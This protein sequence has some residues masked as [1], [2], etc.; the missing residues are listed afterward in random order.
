LRHAA[1]TR[2]LLAIASERPT[3][4][5]GGPKVPTG[6]INDSGIESSLL[7]DFWR[8]FAQLRPVTYSD[9]TTL[10]D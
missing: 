6:G 2:A 4:S 5:I 7:R 1:G 9:K 8:G 10:Y 3:S